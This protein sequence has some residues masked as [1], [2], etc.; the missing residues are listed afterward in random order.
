MVLEDNKFFN[1]EWF[2]LK[3]PTDKRKY[4]NEKCLGIDPII[5]YLDD[6]ADA[7]E[8]FSEQMDQ[9]GIK[10]IVSNNL[11]EIMMHIKE[12]RLSTLLVVSDYHMDGIDVFDFRKRVQE[13]STDIPFYMLSG[14]VDKDLAMKGLGAKI[15][16]FLEKPLDIEE[17][18]EII[19]SESEI[20]LASLVEDYEILQGF[21]GDAE[22]LMEKMDDI[23]D[24]IESADNKK[25]LM[26]S[27]FGMVH[28]IKGSSGFFNPKTLHGFSHHFEDFIK[29]M[30]NDPQHFSLDQ[31]S[32]WQKAVDLMKILVEE[33]KTGKHQD[34]VVDEMIEIFAVEAKEKNNQKKDVQESKKKEVAKKSND[35]KVSIDLLDNFMYLSGEMTVIR[36]MI[37]K[38]VQ[39]LE[40][41]YSSDVEVKNLSDLL[42][43]MNKINLLIQNKVVEIRRISLKGITKSISRI[44]KE[45]ARSLKKEINFSFKGDDLRVD[46]IIF[47]V[48][49]NSMVHLIRNSIDHGVE[50]NEKRVKVGKK[51]KGSIE[52]SFEQ[53]DEFV[54]ASIRDDG[55]G[56]NIEKVKEKVLEK[57]LMTYDELERLNNSE[58]NY[59]IFLPGFSTAEEVTEFSGRG[60]GMSSVKENIESI[61]GTLIVESKQ[62]EGSEFLLKAP[63]P[64]SVLIISCLFVEVQKKLYGI[65]RDYIVKVIDFNFINKNIVKEINGDKCLD[66]EGEV[67]PLLVLEE[68]IFETK[69]KDIHKIIILKTENNLFGLAIDEISDIEDAVIRSFQFEAL[70]RTKIFLGGTFL[71]DGSVGLVFD[72]DGIAEKT[73]IVTRKKQKDESVNFDEVEQEKSYMV[74]NIPSIRGSFCLEQEKIIR[75]ETIP[76][77]K[78]DTGSN[79]LLTTYRDSLL[80][81]IPFDGDLEKTEDLQV[82][83][84]GKVGKNYLGVIVTG[85]NDVIL[86]KDKMKTEISNH[87]LSSEIITIGEKIYTVLDLKK[88]KIKKEITSI[89]TSP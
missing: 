20:R 78:K 28:T 10:T 56:I 50:H 1:K 74:F 22:N 58:I 53:K 69:V 76:K 39:S 61:G 24:E 3:N 57:N 83:V 59:L 32:V 88:I 21:I 7:L 12:N 48:F 67:I 18:I 26:D 25:E 62:G 30:T 79:I 64:K 44:A 49:S 38:E 34:Y 13:V 5:F 85:I 71:G 33:F 80:Y 45:T 2:S 81:I 47:E 70:K 15:A 19:A 46:Q 75:I 82:I 36:N 23:I 68:V 52:I 60:V 35:L 27:M 55:G 8:V 16:S 42:D 86:V 11:D 89:Q 4:I 72:V 9:L 40:K 73:K 77:A 29:K 63:I 17:F 54:I 51:E 65:P 14:F 41:K 6:E 43:E 37:N 66:F 87:H 31:I 84:V